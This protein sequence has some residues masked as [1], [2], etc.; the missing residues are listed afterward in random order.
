M[1]NGSFSKVF[2]LFHECSCHQFAAAAG[3]IY[4]GFLSLPLFIP[5]NN[6]KN[7]S[8]SPL[9]V[10]INMK[11]HT[12]LLPSLLLV[13]PTIKTVDKLGNIK[14][15]KMSW[16]ELWVKDIRLAFL[17]EQLMMC[18]QLQESWTS[19][20][21]KTQMSNTSSDPEKQAW[22]KEETQPRPERVD[23]HCEKAEAKTQIWFS[24]QESPTTPPS[25]LVKHAGI[26]ADRIFNL[27][28]GDDVSRIVQ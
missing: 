27:K 4:A 12:S 23:N 5:F 6:L 8:G 7:S 20:L 10:A 2:H 26:T 21:V 18:S 14:K 13:S 9:P 16:K 17:W 28:V 19:G 15:R 25:S 1:C 11:N 22:L 24:L 3:G